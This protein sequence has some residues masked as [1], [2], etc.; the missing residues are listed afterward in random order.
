VTSDRYDDLI[1]GSRAGGG[2]LAWSLAP[3][4]FAG[5]GLGA[6]VT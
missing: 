3:A 2:T 6:P 5:V 4:G 1:I